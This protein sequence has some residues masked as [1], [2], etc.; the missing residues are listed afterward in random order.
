MFNS[1]FS[2]TLHEKR[3]MMLGWGLGVFAMSLLMIGFYHS[4]SDGNFDELVKSLPGSMKSLIGDLA[5]LKTVPGYVSQQVYAFRI[6]LLTIIM[7]TILYSGLLAGDEGDG[8][9]QV[10][11]TK[12]VSRSRVVL[13]KYFAG[14]VVCLV[15]CFGSVP[16]V[17]LGLTIIK[18]SMSFWML[19]Q[20]ALG[21][22]LVTVAFGSVAYGLGAISGKR[23]QAGS[24]AGVVVFVS[25]LI[26]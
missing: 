14:L 10:L 23:G 16:G 5:A 17:L 13:E 12:P 8:Q 21:C 1:I 20:A 24:I 7:S 9:L 19:A 22:W 25:Y 3:W 2:K 6:P 11:L 26:T 15:V 4:F 18:E